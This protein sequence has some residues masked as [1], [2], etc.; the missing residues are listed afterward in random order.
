MSLF[1]TVRLELPIL[2]TSVKSAPDV[3]VT[4]EQQTRAQNGA[5][6]L[7]I[8]AT[9]EGLSDF[10]DGLDADETV[11]RWILVGRSETRKLYRTRLA[12][13]TG[14]CMNYNEWTD[15]KAVILSSK[16]AA[17]GWTVD[18]F[19]TDR[20][21]LQQF[22][23]SC[24]ANDVS[25][26]LLRVSEVDQLQDVH[27][28]GLTELQSDTLLAAFDRG[29]FS[30]PRKVNLEEL[31]APLDVSHQALS[32]RLRRGVNSLIENTIA[33][34]RRGGVLP[35]AS[36]RTSPANVPSQEVRV[37]LPLALEL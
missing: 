31:A 19:V 23:N 20:S 12:P 32:E 33:D 35:T 5:L 2:E 15:G 17:S 16:R 30:V 7:T 8:W 25:F 26:D 37:K 21:A 9:G 10:E 14:S 13:R 18:A 1:V 36:D 27:R 29:F 34:Q 28:F 22:A 11:D 24:E 4:I 6:D 3:D